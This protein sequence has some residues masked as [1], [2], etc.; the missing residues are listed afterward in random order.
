MKNLLGLVIVSILKQFLMK[1]IIILIGFI[2]PIVCFS[3]VEP[4]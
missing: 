2:I 4:Q 1:N 3:Q